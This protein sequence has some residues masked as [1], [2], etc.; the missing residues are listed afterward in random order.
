M[1]GRPCLGLRR[2]D[3]RRGSDRDPERAAAAGDRSSA[4]P[5]RA[6]LGIRAR[7][8]ARCVD[9]R[10]HVPR[11]AAGDQRRLVRV[12]AGHSAARLGGD[13]RAGG[14]L[15]HERRRHLHLPGHPAHRAALGRTDPDRCSR[16]RLSR[17]RRPRPARVAAG[18]ARRQR[19][20]ARE[21]GSERHAPARRVG[22]RFLVPDRSKPGGDPARFER[23]HLRVSLGRE[24]DRTADD[25]LGPCRLCRDRTSPFE[26]PRLVDRRGREQGKPA[27]GRRRPHDPDGQQAGG[28]EGG[29]SRLPR[30]SRQ[31][32]QRHASAGAPDVGG[33]PRGA[34]S[35]PCSPARCP[36]ARAPRR[37]LS[38]PAGDDVRVRPRS[39]RVRRDLRHGKGE[40]GCLRDILE[41]RRGG[42]PL[43]SRACGHTGGAAQA[44]RAVR[45]DRP[46]P[47]LLGE[48]VRDRRALGSRTDAGRDV[49]ATQRLRTGGPCRALTR[50]RQRRR[51]FRR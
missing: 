27:V 5:V 51:H 17:D 19:A 16:D 15:R 23:R 49:L 2:S 3:R 24:G 25:L 34:R 35:N 20:G 47:S 48:A 45:P 31:R 7:A 41:L 38:P 43:G 42:T 21:L 29:E 26:R 30:V 8:P 22:D 18:D 12:G 6:H 28:G 40:T 11:S 39:A 1:P 33:D 9:A 10:D 32:L 13:H 14:C 50:R 36:A 37:D 4:A 44:R 46:R